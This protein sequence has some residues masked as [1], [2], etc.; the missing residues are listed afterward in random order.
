MPAPPLNW[1][2]SQARY[3]AAGKTADVG[4]IGVIC[5]HMDYTGFYKDAGIKPTVFRAGEFKALGNH[6]EALS[7]KAKE[8]LQTHLEKSCQIFIEAVAS[9]RKKLKISES[10]GMG[11]RSRFPR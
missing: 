2:G 3:F 10:K 4:S 1:A 6:L 8:Y 7:P 5:I 11:R 9:G